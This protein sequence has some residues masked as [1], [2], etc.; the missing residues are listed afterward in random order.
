MIENQSIPENFKEKFNIFLALLKM[1]L[2]FIVVN[3]HCFD[4]SRLN[5]KIIIKLLYNKIPVPIFFIISF[6]YFFNLSI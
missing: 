6:Y 1:Y 2:E 4:P 5:N 3:S